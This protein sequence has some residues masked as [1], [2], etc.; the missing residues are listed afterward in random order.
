MTLSFFLSWS[1]A[2]QWWKRLSEDRRCPAESLLQFIF[3]FFTCTA[4]CHRRSLEPFVTKSH[5]SLARVPLNTFRSFVF[6]TSRGCTHQKAWIN[7]IKFTQTDDKLCS[8]TCLD[9]SWGEM[10]LNYQLLLLSLFP[11]PSW[12][13]H[14]GSCSRSFVCFCFVFFETLALFL[15]AC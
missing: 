9:S 11:V 14:Q 10:L 7:Q 13:C 1:E 6:L 2:S 3:L 5:P 4:M 8:S 12:K 15:L